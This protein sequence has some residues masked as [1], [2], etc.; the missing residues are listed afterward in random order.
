MQGCRSIVDARNAK[1]HKKA[2]KLAEACAFFGIEQ[3]SAHGAFSDAWDVLEI[4]R[5]LRER[6][7][8]PVFTDPYDREKV[9]NKDSE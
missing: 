5:K 1:G 2:P 3:R 6:G 8:M 7:A 4:M 9:V